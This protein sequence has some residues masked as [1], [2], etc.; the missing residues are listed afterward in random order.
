[1]DEKTL[2]KF[3]RLVLSIGVNLQKD[4]GLEVICPVEKSEVA[5]AFTE[6]AYKLNAKIVNIRW[7][8]ERTDSIPARRHLWRFPPGWQ[9]S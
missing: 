5:V 2:K 6:E 4:Q 8:S 9:H 7:Y 1:M 3:A